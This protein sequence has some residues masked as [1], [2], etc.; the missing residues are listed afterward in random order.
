[1]CICIR[2]ADEGRRFLLTLVYLLVE[3]EFPAQL[4][5]SLESFF[6]LDNKSTLCPK[7]P[8]T[9]HFLESRNE[10]I[11]LEKTTGGDGGG[12]YLHLV[13]RQERCRS[14]DPTVKTKTGDNYYRN[15]NE[16]MNWTLTWSSHLQPLLFPAAGI[17]RLIWFCIHFLIACQHFIITVSR[18][19]CSTCCC[20]L[21]HVSPLTRL[22]KTHI[23]LIKNKKVKLQAASWLTCDH[24]AINGGF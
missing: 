6:P 17:W 10:F 15:W 3:L 2:W 5:F 8:K 16:D 13:V 23:I 14:A 20:S 22:L 18:Q 4:C 12:V 19:L 7:T 9:S 1:M 24:T 21:R 11:T